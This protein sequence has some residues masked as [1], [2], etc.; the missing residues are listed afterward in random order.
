MALAATEGEQYVSDGIAG[1]HSPFARDFID[2]L[3]TDGGA[4]GNGILITSEFA[5]T[6]FENKQKPRFG[7]LS[8]DDDPGSDFV[9]ILLDEKERKNQQSDKKSNEKSIGP[10]LKS[11]KC[12]FQKYG[13]EKYNPQ[14]VCGK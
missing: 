13:K 8:D 2:I 11:C 4:D 9:L 10:G 5:T 6:L 12:I 7:K 14:E 1:K 3:L